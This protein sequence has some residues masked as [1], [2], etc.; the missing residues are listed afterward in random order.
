MKSGNYS[1]Y[2][3]DQAPRIGSGRRLVRARIGPKWVRLWTLTR[4]PSSQRI[5]RARWNEVAPTARPI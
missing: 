2:L 1:V 4:R 5:K 3:E